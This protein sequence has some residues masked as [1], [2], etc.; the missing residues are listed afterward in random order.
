MVGLLL[1]SDQEQQQQHHEKHPEID[2]LDHAVLREEKQLSKPRWNHRCFSPSI[3]DI[4]MVISKT[5]NKP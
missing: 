3:S 5:G 1:S 4:L 2:V